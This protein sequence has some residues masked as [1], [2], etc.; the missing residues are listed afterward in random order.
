MTTVS[1]R[2]PLPDPP[3]GFDEEI[4]ALVNATAPRLF[5]VV[6]EY[7][8]AEGERDAHV[9]AWGLAYEDGSAHVASAGA[10]FRMSLRRPERAA[11]LISLRP[12]SVG[13]VV[14]A[15]PVAYASGRV[16]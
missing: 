10:G 15:G 12:G 11:Q 14:W 4:H 13:S 8:T 9:A 5:A 1:S 6:E 7:A 2:P 3:D 16:E